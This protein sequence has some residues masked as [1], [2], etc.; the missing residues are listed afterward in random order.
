MEK[1]NKKALYESIMKT[2][3]EQVKKALNESADGWDLR[4]DSMLMETFDDIESAIYEIKNC[5]RGA[6]TGCETYEELGQHLRDL[7]QSLM[8]CAGEIEGMEEPEEPEEQ[9]IF[10]DE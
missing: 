5:V 2:V 6:Y 9:E 7:G 1:D 10:D 4:D 3:S 8:E